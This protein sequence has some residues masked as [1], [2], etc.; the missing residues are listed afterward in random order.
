[1][2]SSGEGASLCNASAT[3]LRTATTAPTR[4]TVVKSGKAALRVNSG[5]RVET[6]CGGSGSATATPTAPRA[7]TSRG[8]RCRSADTGLACAPATLPSRIASPSSCLP[9]SCRDGTC[10]DEKDVCDG[11]LHCRDGS[12]EE[13]CPPPRPPRPPRCSPSEFTCRDGACL[14]ERFLCDGTP[15]VCFLSN[16]H[17]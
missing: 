3:G 2:D 17:F 16:I 9:C 10:L 11:V 4:P 6:A 12:D 8:A 7:T 14:P 1:M 15:Q 5:V 13:R